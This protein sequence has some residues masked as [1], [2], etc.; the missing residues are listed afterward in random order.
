MLY[1]PDVTIYQYNLLDVSVFRTDEWTDKHAD[2]YSAPQ[3]CGT[4]TIPIA[5]GRLV[6]DGKHEEKGWTSFVYPASKIG[7]TDLTI[8]QQKDFDEDSSR[9]DIVVNSVSTHAYQMANF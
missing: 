2:Y 5:F 6:K 1:I 9:E 3:L 4:L 8:F 7:V